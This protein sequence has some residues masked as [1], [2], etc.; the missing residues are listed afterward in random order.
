M[1]S[2]SD[3]RL[4]QTQVC[5]SARIFTMSTSV[6]GA[7]MSCVCIFVWANFHHES[8]PSFIFSD[9]AVV[10]GNSIDAYTT[11]GT[12]LSLGIRGSRI[13][14]VLPPPEPGV[15]GF[16]DSS[17]ENA[18]VMAMENAEVR[19]HRNC[20]L[21][22]FNNGEQADPLTSASFTTSTE[23]LRLQCGVSRSFRWFSKSARCFP[24]SPRRLISSYR[25]KWY[26]NNSGYW[27]RC[28]VE[29]DEPDRLNSPDCG[30][31]L[32]VNF[33]PGSK[34]CLS[35]TKWFWF[36]SHFHHSH[37]LREKTTLL[38]GVFFLS[39][40]SCWIL[41]FTLWDDP[42]FKGCSFTKKL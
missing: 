5:R 40:A 3:A 28:L 34:L 2:L 32:D 6:L 13:S 19:V 16:M 38:L 11:V 14:L 21:A 33:P 7:V 1:F 9:T 29:L 37:C 4:T 17:V 36:S 31:W 12:L 39:A 8:F 18:V 35:S 42:A 27:P 15:S 22:R 10:Y 26:P 23:P 25:K 41:C 30:S 20:V 24:R